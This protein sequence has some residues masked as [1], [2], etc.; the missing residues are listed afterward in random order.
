MVVLAYAEAHAVQIFCSHPVLAYA[1][2]VFSSILL[3]M[4]YFERAKN[5]NFDHILAGNLSEAA[6]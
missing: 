5:I 3:S 4:I 2:L 1:Q 6:S